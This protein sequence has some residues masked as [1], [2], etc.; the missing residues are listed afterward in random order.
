MGNR[1]SFSKEVL[2]IEKVAQKHRDFENGL[3]FYYNA[4]GLPRRDLKFVGYSR[5]D[6]VRELDE[7]LR[8][9]DRDSAFG[10]LAALEASFRVDFH[11]RCEKRLK[12]DLSRHFRRLDKRSLRRLAFEEQILEA[13]KRH[14][15]AA[16]TL[17]SEIIGAFK[18]RH[19]LAHGRYWE[20]K[21]GKRYDFFSV[22]LLAQ[23]MEQV[24]QKSD[25]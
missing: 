5:D 24:F 19:W 13:W 11:L 18:Y 4:P 10:I 14:V 21:L 1:V 9:L 6:L 25:N 23:R 17:I 15:P 22:Y 12:D 8:D 7:R 3:R 2:T 16:K 20:P